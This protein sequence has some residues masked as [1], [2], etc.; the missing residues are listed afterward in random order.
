MWWSRYY[1]L[2]LAARLNEFND[3]VR[4]AAVSHVDSLLVTVGTLFPF[5]KPTWRLRDDP[6]LGCRDLCVVVVAAGTRVNLGGRDQDGPA[7]C[8]PGGCA[9]P[10]HVARPAD[11]GVRGCGHRRAG[12]AAQHTMVCP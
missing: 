5:G 12:T 2:A 9:V 4:Q 6:L 3:H 1:D 11:T 10:V 8:G 7:V